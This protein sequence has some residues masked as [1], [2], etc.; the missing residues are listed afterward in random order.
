MFGK[1]ILKGLAVT[2]KEAAS[3]H[4]TEKYPEEKPALPSRWRGGKFALDKEACISCGLCAMSCPNKV[5]RQ[6]FEK[7]E[8]NK[9]ICTEF[10]MERQYC[11]FCGL[12]VEACPKGCL[13]LTHEFETAV[14]LSSDVPQ[15]L[16]ADNNMEAEI[17]AY[18]QKPKPQLPP[19]PAAAPSAAPAP[20]QAA[21][22][23]GEGGAE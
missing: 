8:E 14:Y 21:Q 4:W 12:C 1:G 22:T 16:L 20:K 17:S 13:H 19:K 23:T 11:L 7:D 6:K 18:G 2:A 5:I 9:K 3:P 10:V 15:D